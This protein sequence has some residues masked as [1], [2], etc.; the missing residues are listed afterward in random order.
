MEHDRQDVA[1]DGVEMTGPADQTRRR[2][3]RSRTDRMLGGVAGGLGDYFDV[4]PVLVRLAWVALAFAGIGV[5]AYI[6]AWI[7]V[8]EEPLAHEGVSE[9]PTAA[10]AARRGNDRTGARIV[11]GS[12]LIAVGGLLLLDWVVPDLNRVLWPLAIIAAGIGL[13]AYG[14]RR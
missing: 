5:V 11:F 10:P 7:I 1:P 6:V 13:F 12:V 2:L 8:P 4:D 3:Y 14:A 9:R